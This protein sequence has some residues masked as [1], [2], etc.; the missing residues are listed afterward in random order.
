MVSSW[1]HLA[2]ATFALENDLTKAGFVHRGKGNGVP[3][4]GLCTGVERRL[5]RCVCMPCVW[6]LCPGV[7]EWDDAGER[8]D[9][10]GGI[11][12]GYG[13]TL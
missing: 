10:E 4:L 6:V 11:G 1:V 13:S 7:G 5:C 2:V 12:E 3:R 8:K 9:E